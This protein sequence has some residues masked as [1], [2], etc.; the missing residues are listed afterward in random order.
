MKILLTGYKGLIGSKIYERL[1]L[2]HEVTGVEKN[3]FVDFIKMSDGDFDMIIHAG[4]N[5]IIR[6]TIKEPE[7]AMQNI[8][9]SYLI[10]EFAR[11]NDIKK[12][13]VFSSSRVEYDNMNPY[14]VSKRFVENIT[15]SYNE[16]YGIDYMII[17]PETVWGSNDNPVRVIPKWVVQALN[18]EVITVYGNKHKML[19]PIHV[20]DFVDL[21]LSYF[22]DWE[23]HKNSI[24]KIAGKPLSVM[25]IIDI[26]K[27]VTH[28]KSKVK[29]SKA[30]LSQPQELAVTNY[31]Y[32]SDEK[33]FE[34]RLEETIKVK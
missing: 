30:E 7:L 19:P 16:C 27:K 11:R 20:E 18:N 34:K 32:D 9:S 6:D 28:S 24:I 8:D 12:V 17:R 23:L 25:Q 21:F 2:F 5:C 10:M 13:I 22:N 4:A 1:K 29:Y 26:I 31:F 33:T 3:Q 15:Q 14:T